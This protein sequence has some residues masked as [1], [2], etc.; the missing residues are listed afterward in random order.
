MM[1]KINNDIEAVRKILGEPVIC[2]FDG[3]T[4]KIRNTLFLFSII[5][6]VYVIAGLKINSK[7]SSILGLKFNGLNDELFHYILFFSVLYLS[8]H[9]IWCAIDT[10]MTW[11]LRITG[12]KVAFVTGFVAGSPAT[13]HPNDPRQTTL[14]NWWKN[15]L[16]PEVRDYNLLSNMKK[17]NDSLDHGIKNIDSILDALEAIKE[18]LQDKSQISGY[19]H[20]INHLSSIRY[21]LDNLI[22]QS[23]HASFIYSS[24]VLVSL[25]RF[26]GWY[27]YS[28]KSQN[29]RWFF[30]EFL[31]P[32]GL[33]FCAIYLLLKDICFDL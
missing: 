23:E 30:V 4:Q 16:L 25:E 19:D 28:L 8:M 17:Y 14:Y 5:S 32:I 2:E 18:T 1:A 22:E 20:A 33:S 29:I 15:Q 13:D 24:R 10:F 26:D 31:T 11:R 27:K 21:N 9:F 6:I 12:T 7:D 3:T